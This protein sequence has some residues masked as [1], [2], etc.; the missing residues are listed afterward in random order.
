MRGINT[1]SVRPLSPR[2]RELLDPDRFDPLALDL[3]RVAVEVDSDLHLLVAVVLC[4]R[5]AP[6]STMKFAERR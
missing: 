1:L 2:S 5:A 3:D 6:P 4:T